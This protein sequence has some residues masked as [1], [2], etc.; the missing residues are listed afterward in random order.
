MEHTNSKYPE[1]M[2]QLL[3]DHMLKEL[4]AHQGSYVELNKSH[5][6]ENRKEVF[7]RV[8]EV[9]KL[10]NINYSIPTP[11]LD[12]TGQSI[13][14]LYYKIKIMTETQML[15]WRQERKRNGTFSERYG[16]REPEWDSN[17][18]RFDI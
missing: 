5:G 9:L 11:E 14:K 6:E 18:H 17:Y 4:F 10:M 16:Y 13:I 1:E 2:I 3:V 7:N 12:P 15:L 8:R